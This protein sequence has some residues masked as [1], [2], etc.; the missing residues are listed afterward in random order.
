VA[1]VKAAKGGNKSKGGGPP[2]SGGKVKGTTK[3]KG[4]KRP[5]DD[6]DGLDGLDLVKLDPEDEEDVKPS[7]T[8]GNAE[9]RRKT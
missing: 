2:G 8:D 4:R 1:D 5:L 7:V 9:K 6:E 3:G